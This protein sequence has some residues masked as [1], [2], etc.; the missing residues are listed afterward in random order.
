MSGGRRHRHEEHEE[1]ENHERWL[2]TYADMVTLLMVLF[3]VMFAISQVDQKKFAELRDGLAAGFGSQ[4]SLLNGSKSLAPEPGANQ[5]APVLGGM[6]GEEQALVQ[7]ALEKTKALEAGRREGDAKAELN[8]LETVRKKL[9]AALKSA[10]LESDLRTSYDGRGLVLSLVS[11]HV[12]FEN[13]LATLT[14]RGLA[15]VDRIGAVLATIPDPVEVDG[16]TNQV[17]VKPKYY[18]TDWDLSAA[19]AL[20][21]LRRLE[22]VAGIPARRLSL[23]AFGHTRPLIDPA[24]P[25]SQELNKR[26]DL[27][28]MAATEQQTTALLPGLA[29]DLARAERA[30]SDRPQGERP[31]GTPSTPSAGEDTAAPGDAPT[32]APVPA[33]PRAGTGRTGTTTTGSTPDTR[34][35]TGTDTPTNP[36]GASR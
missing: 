14:P 29:A 11:K 24:K 35:D 5:A 16:H 33:A 34:T 17:P 21:V 28:V 12:V 8:R 26:V 10:G 31:G 30:S 9:E 15:I 6:S 18:P 13:D 2:V 7:A 19:R 36:R 25:G 32:L 23:A 27:V 4:D 22:A 20:T 1:H 3:I